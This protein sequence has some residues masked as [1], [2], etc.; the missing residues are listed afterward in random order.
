MI[1]PE[2]VPTAVSLV[3]KFALAPLTIEKETPDIVFVLISIIVSLGI[4]D[5][6]FRS[7][8]YIVQK[9]IEF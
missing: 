7:P 3:A 6:F 5:P 4:V 1:V 9:H 8:L 2:K